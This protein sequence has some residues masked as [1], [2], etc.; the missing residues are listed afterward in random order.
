[1]TTTLP[2]VSLF[3]ALQG[4]DAWLD[5]MFGVLGKSVCHNYLHCA[6]LTSALVGVTSST[7]Q[8]GG[9]N[10]PPYCVA[11]LVMDSLDYSV[12]KCFITYAMYMAAYVELS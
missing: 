5:S 1:M 7:C 10:G 4:F 3:I 6:P 11:D 9:R 12:G 2:F 8:V